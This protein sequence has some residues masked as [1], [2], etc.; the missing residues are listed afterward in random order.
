MY[1]FL[2][3]NIYPG[4]EA[5][6]SGIF[7]A[8]WLIIHCF[9]HYAVFVSNYIYCK[10]T[11]DI[12]MDQ[13]QKLLEEVAAI[14]LAGDPEPWRRIAF[15]VNC[16]F[17]EDECN[18]PLFYGGEQCRRFFV[19]DILRPMDPESYKMGWFFEGKL[20]KTYC[21]DVSNR[22]LAEKAIANYRKN[23]LEEF[24]DLSEINSNAGWNDLLFEKVHRIIMAI[25]LGAVLIEFVSILF[26]GLASI[27]VCIYYAISN[28]SGFPSSR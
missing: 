16:W 13:L 17:A 24:D 2:Y 12:E 3:E 26:L 22:M 14:N 11:V 23:N 27:V 4:F 1:F 19:R 5:D 6:V 28:A 21:E 25:V 10:A 7:S 8:S 18:N 9:V 15:R 20:V